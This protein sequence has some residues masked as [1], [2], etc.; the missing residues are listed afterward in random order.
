MLLSVIFGTCHDSQILGSVLY[1]SVQEAFLCATSFVLY[2]WLGL[3]LATS[4]R[5]FDI[6]LDQYLYNF[7]IHF[8]LVF[9]VLLFQ[10]SLLRKQTEKVVEK[11]SK[12][13]CFMTALFVRL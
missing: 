4:L 6:I 10:S 7:P 13:S 8:F 1:Q 3:F 9:W 12:K 2:F 11:K 5:E